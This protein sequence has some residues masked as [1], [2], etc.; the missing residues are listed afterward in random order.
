MRPK[1]RILL[2]DSNE[3]RRSVRK[4]VLINRGFIVHAAATAEEA[5][6]AAATTK[7]NAKFDVVIGCWPLEDADLAAAL[8]TLHKHH[9]ELR[10]MVIAET[11][12]ER[13][14]LLIADAVLLKGQCSQFEIHE[15]ARLLAARKRGPQK[16][17]PAGQR[18]PAD[19]VAYLGVMETIDRRTA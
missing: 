15:S 17:M 7:F 12:T 1:K 5:H 11:L 13:P 2:I 14:N 8:D 18:A 16:F 6:Q 19:M 10:S 9:P 3:A 4:F